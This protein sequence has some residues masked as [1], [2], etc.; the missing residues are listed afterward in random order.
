M[1][2]I[3]ALFLVNVFVSATLASCVALV[4]WGTDR[5]LMRWAVA[6]SLHGISYGLL[7]MRGVLPDFLTVVV[8]NTLVATMFALFAE[9][10]LQFLQRTLSRVIVWAPVV[11]LFFAFLL[12]AEQFVAR[13]VL[14]AAIFSAQSLLLIVIVLQGFAHRVGR[15]KWIIV[16]A[17][18]VSIA[19]LLHRGLLTLLGND[20][21]VDLQSSSLLQI[22]TFIGA[23]L[24]LMMF[25]IG[26]LVAY[27]ERAEHHSLVLALHDP[28]TLLG[29]RRLLQERQQMAL[30]SSAVHG[31]FG[32]KLLLD[33]DRF[34]ALNDTHGHAVG[35][36]LLVETA[37]RLQQALNEDDTVVRLGGDEFVVLIEGLDTVKDKALEK[38]GTVARRIRDALSQPF[39][40]KLP[41]VDG[42]VIHYQCSCSIGVALFLGRSVDSEELFKRADA[43]MYL[44]KQSRTDG[45]HFHDTADAAT[46]RPIPE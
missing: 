39:V 29:N 13:V 2:D 46:P 16:I 11:F 24:A 18:V 22:I 42:D 3:Q 41:A 20:A 10:M 35:D 6:F 31:K 4:G 15:G 27:K 23:A 7:A 28:L 45:I 21:L 12:L 40:L 36:Q 34:K 44:A 9:A 38:A 43:A 1:T 30:Q 25:A 26:V 5:S 14:S 19:L 8:A 32:G 33:L 17:A 37:L